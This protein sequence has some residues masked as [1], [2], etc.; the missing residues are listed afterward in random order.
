[1]ARLFEYAVIYHPKETS[2]AQGNDTT[3]KDELLTAPTSILASSDR[4][5]GIIA[6]RGI[7]AK[8]LDKLDQVEVV[9]RP[10]A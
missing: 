7:D 4:E 5:V 9:I 1:M 2:D 10:F 3:P 8:Y 6:G